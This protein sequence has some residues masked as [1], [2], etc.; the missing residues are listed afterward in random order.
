MMIAQHCI[1][2]AVTAVKRETVSPAAHRLLDYLL[3][4]EA[5]LTHEI[6]RDCAIGN[7]SA[8]A[9]LVRPALQRHGLAIVAD[10]PKPQI[11]NR[12]GELSMSHEWR[13]VRT[14]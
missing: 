7:I 14:R 3:T 10:L 6:A 11:K 5:A 2:E 4:N 1:D 8:A 12:F 9:N 13:L